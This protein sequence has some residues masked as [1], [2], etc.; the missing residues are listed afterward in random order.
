MSLTDGGI[1]ACIVLLFS[2]AVYDKFIMPQRHGQTLLKVPL[3]RKTRLDCLI[4][5]LL[6]G[7]LIYRNITTEGSTLTTYL[8][9]TL[10]LITAYLAYIRQP[11][12]L[13]KPT[14]LFFANAYI[15][16]Q[17]I[18]SMNLTED[19]VL[20]FGLDSGK[21]PIELHK[22]DDLDQITV[23]FQIRSTIRDSFKK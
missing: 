13:F 14:G 5:V 4:F 9:I 8:L 20:V 1:I 11:K 18:Q 23:L 15:D 10:A 21:L 7:I 6:I 3:L 19:G 12:L 16:Y 22:I 2:Y 17:R